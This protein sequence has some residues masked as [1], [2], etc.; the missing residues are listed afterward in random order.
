MALVV[1]DLDT[2]VPLEPVQWSSRLHLEPTVPYYSLQVNK[3]YAIQCIV[4]NSR[5]Q[6]QVAW[7]NRTAPIS[8]E[9]KQLDSADFLLPV[10]TKRHRL[11]SFVRSVGHANGTFR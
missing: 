1:R 10:D 9:P 2:D 11:S 8:A 4:E 5:P 6:S 7:F 3:L